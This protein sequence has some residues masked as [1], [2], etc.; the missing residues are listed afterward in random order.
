MTPAHLTSLQGGHVPTEVLPEI[1]TDWIGPCERDMGGDRWDGVVAGAG[2]WWP[3]ASPRGIRFGLRRPEV[4]HRI[5]CVMHTTAPA[6][7][8]LP[9]SEGGQLPDSLAEHSPLLLACHVAR[10]VMGVCGIVGVLGKWYRDAYMVRDARDC[11]TRRQDAVV[12]L[13]S[14]SAANGSP[15]W[16]VDDEHG[17][18]VAFGTEVDEA[19]R[20]CA[21][22]AALAAGFALLSND[23]TATLPWPEVTP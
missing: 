11:L 10:V 22:A 6:W 19:G 20:A 2:L 14:A 3:G 8:L 4:R 15:T 16:Q 13:I 9:V 17:S 1:L 21:D 18:G 5:A 12:S 23:N 7:H